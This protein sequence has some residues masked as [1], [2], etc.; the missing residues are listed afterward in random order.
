MFTWSHQC[1]MDVDLS[2]LKA[3]NFYTN[4]T[5]W[6]KWEDRFEAFLLEGTLKVGSQI[7]AK[8][9]NK[10]NH[11]IFLITDLCLYKECTCLVKVLFFTQKC[12]CTFHE[13][14]PEKTRITLQINVSSFFT[15]FMKKIFLKNMEN[16]HS[17]CLNAFAEIVENQMH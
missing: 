2:L 5:N 9:K 16:T 10:P 6:L 12:L 13:I 14:S 17:K 1:S 3:W 11:I 7:K 4:P 15:P 8:I